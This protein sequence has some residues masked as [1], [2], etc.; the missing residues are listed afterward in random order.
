VLAGIWLLPAPVFGVVSIA[1][2]VPSVPSPTPVGATIAFATTASDTDAGNLRYRYRVSYNGG[3]YSTII[4]YGPSS[5]FLW[6]PTGAEGNYNIEVSVVNRT[7]GSTAA[8][9]IPFTVM[10]AAF[11]GVPTVNATAHP[12]VA[13]YSA[14]PC[15]AGAMQVRFKMDSETEWHHTS[16]K[17]CNGTTSMNFLVG[18]MYQNS[19]YTMVSDV[20]DGLLVTTS[21]PVTFTTGTAAVSLPP[22]ST[23]IPF[24]APSSVTESIT[25][26]MGLF[27]FEYAV[28]TNSN[29]LWYLPGFYYY[30]TRPVPGGTFLVVYGDTRELETSGLREYD[31]AGN[32]LKD[33]NVEQVNTE[34]QAMGL[35]FT[36]NA[37]HH[38]VRKLSNGDYLLLA[39]TE[40]LGFAQGPGVDILGDVVLL[41]DNNLQVLWAWNSFDNLDVSRAAVLGETCQTNQAGCVAFLAPVANDWTHSNSVALTPDGNIIVSSRHQDFV[42][43]IAYEN[44]AGDGHVIWRLGKGGDFTWISS[45][46]YP[47]QSHQ[48]DADYPEP[49]VLTLY[50]NGNTRV[51][52]FGG[53]SRGM[54]LL[55]DEVNLTATPILSADVGVYSMALGAAQKLFNGTYWFDSG[56]IAAGAQSVEVN[57]SGTIISQIDVTGVAIYRTFRLADLYSAPMASDFRPAPHRN[58][59]GAA[60]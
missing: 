36:V 26:L 40:E 54:A 44:G 22:T 13:L 35:S 25:L 59:S 8:T 9:S 60:E 15:A 17:A 3:A 43:K 18:G 2:L 34:L 27:D 29:L 6:T 45:D 31:L 28:D 1:S 11:G 30:G 49:T 10:P 33:T 16:A 7:T 53:D 55:L 39:Q 20:I 32:I 48:H 4:D 46:P 42:Y 38:D 50:D 12:M 56:I 58:T 21:G 47:W 5:T 41:V 23:A 24:I 51:A 37:F 19:T 57:S 14:P 52:S